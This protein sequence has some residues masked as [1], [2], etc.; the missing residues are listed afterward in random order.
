MLDRP[1]TKTTSEATDGPARVSRLTQGLRFF[2]VVLAL[3][4][5]LDLSL[6]L[7][8]VPLRSSAEDLASAKSHDPGLVDHLLAASCRPD[9]LTAVKINATISVTLMRVAGQA[10]SDDRMQAIEDEL[11]NVARCA[12]YD[13]DAWARVASVGFQRSGDTPQVRAALAMSGWTAP[14]DGTAIR[15]RISVLSRLLA[16]GDPRIAADLTQDIRRF[17]KSEPVGDILSLYAS[18]D[19]PIREML[20][21][22]VQL[23]LDVEKRNALMAPMKGPA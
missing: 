11:R 7:A 19:E 10:P 8:S 6:S 12:P 22:A 20:R 4:G 2:V 16:S 3:L 14:H 21:D 5:L 15:T 1:D 23:L 17:T 13:G 18:S 9:I